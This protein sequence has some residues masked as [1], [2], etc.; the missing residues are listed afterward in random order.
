MVSDLSNKT[1]GFKYHTTVKVLLKKYKLNGE[2]EFRPVYF[3]SVTKAV[4]NHRFKLE[5]SFQGILYKIDNWIKD[6]AGLL[7]L[8]SLNTLIFQ[9]ID[10]YQEVLI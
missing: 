1:K 4:R 8:L 2:T 3:N 7:N 9:L 6:L 5:S 10:H